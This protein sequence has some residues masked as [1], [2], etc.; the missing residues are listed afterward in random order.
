MT[1]RT[2]FLNAS[3]IESNEDRQ[4]S[5]GDRHSVESGREGNDECIDA[6]WKFISQ[7]QTQSRNLIFVPSSSEPH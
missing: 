7:R 1:A 5:K 4:H 6:N 3:E 2:I